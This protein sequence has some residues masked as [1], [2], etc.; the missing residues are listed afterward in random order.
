MTLDVE[1]DGR[2]VGSQKVQF[3][4]DG[5]P[6]AVRVRAT[7]SEPGPRVF[8]FR[9]APQQGEVVTQN[10]QRDSLVEVRDTREK[11]LYFEGEPRS[12]MKFITP[13]RRRRQEPADRHAAAHRGQQVPPSRRRSR[14]VDELLGG[15]PK[16]RDELFAFKG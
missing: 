9:V 11:I 13:R 15:F 14:N 8:S 12:E 2:I 3:P 4:A 10:N 7:A 6:A 16:T 5:S 1:D